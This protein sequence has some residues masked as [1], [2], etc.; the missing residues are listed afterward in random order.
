MRIYD[1]AILI[2]GANRSIGQALVD[3]AW[4]DTRGVALFDDLSDR[5]AL[6]QHLAI[7][8]FGTYGVT[9]TSC[10]FWFGLKERS[11]TTCRWRPLPRC[12]S[13]PAP[14]TPI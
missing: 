6:E 9:Q 13:C 3:E 1:K 10:R 11:S 8:L 5:A 2:T 14:W 12:R 7:N 4:G